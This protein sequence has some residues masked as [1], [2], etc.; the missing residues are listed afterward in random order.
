MPEL[1]LIRLTCLFSVQFPEG[2]ARN[3]INLRNGG[4]HNQFAQR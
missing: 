1:K 3:T 4:R 2:N